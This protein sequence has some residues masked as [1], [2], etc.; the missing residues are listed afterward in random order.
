MIQLALAFFG[1]TA[2]YMATGNNARA[3]RWAPLRATV[4]ACLRGAVIGLGPA[5]PV[6][7]LQ[8]RLCARR[9]GAVE[10]AVKAALAF[11]AWLLSTSAALALYMAWLSQPFI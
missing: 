7:G 10:A 4:L 11:A 3:R 6:A 1:L 8:R 2:L 9:V 5:G